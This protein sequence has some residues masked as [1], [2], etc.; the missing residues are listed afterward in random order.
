MMRADDVTDQFITVFDHGFVHHGVTMFD[1]LRRWHPQARLAV[2]AMDARCMDILRRLNCPDLVVIPVEQV[3][4]DRLRAVRPQRTRAEFCWTLSPVAV[5]TALALA[6]P[7]GCGI[8][9][10]ADLWFRGRIDGWFAAMEGQPA[11][12]QIVEHGF[13]PTQKQRWEH[14]AGRFC[15][16]WVAAREGA[17]ARRLLHWWR[18][19]CTEWCFH[20]FEPGRFGDQKYLDA[21]PERAEGR[22]HILPGS[23]I[24]APWNMD[25]YARTVESPWN[26]SCFHFHTFRAIT[27][28]W[29][30]VKGYRIPA[31]A[32]DWYASYQEE[33]ESTM[34][35]IRAV[36]A[37][38]SPS[39]MDPHG[40]WQRAKAVAGLITGLETRK[41]FRHG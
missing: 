24:G 40:L 33:L 38:W 6:G 25:G 27:N 22:L 37:N 32:Q 2:I 21:W 36:D 17:V 23:V 13:S 41:D 29:R 15:V 19:R 5:Q 4:D 34:A 16:Q 26:P 9:V 31:V 14:K 39:R 3:L 28:G 11:E 18:E 8:Y 7:G 10:D 12:L 35:R 1:S 20:R 30:W